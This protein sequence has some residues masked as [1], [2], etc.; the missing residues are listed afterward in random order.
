M[1]DEHDL[2]AR[3]GSLGEALDLPPARTSL[4]V[5]EV[6]ARL[7]EP[8]RPVA[9]PPSV[10]HRRRVA[11]AAA[12]AVVVAGGV[13]AVPDARH[14]VA[15]W[16]GLDSVSIEVDPDLSSSPHD[17]TFT[18][19]GP[20]ESRVVTVDGRE[21]LVSAIAGEFDEVLIFKTVRSSDQVLPVD[22]AGRRGLWIAGDP[23]EV[24]YRALDGSVLVERVAADTLL[25][26]GA[27][28]LLRV[29]GFTELDAA[30]DYAAEITAAGTP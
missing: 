28:V 11:L 12:V 23:H 18:K 13:L 2:I 15:Q 21:I 26:Q 10:R 8:A 6:L 16:L 24:M 3:L 20:G 9:H 7:D 17:G 22:V 25:W 19:P 27:D 30:L 29:E 1:I 5:D 14:A 4:V